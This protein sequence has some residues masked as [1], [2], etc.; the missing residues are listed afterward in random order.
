MKL[1]Y[2]QAFYFRFSL[3]QN[4]A[5]KYL[6]RNGQK[7]GFWGSIRDH[8]RVDIR[9]KWPN[10]RYSAETNFFCFGRTLVLRSNSFP[11][12]KLFSNDDRKIGVFPQFFKNYDP[13][14]ETKFVS[15]CN[16]IKM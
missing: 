7:L 9:W 10:I 3:V 4:C 14:W 12:M 15:K 1:T 8:S 6:F 5:N 2:F 16:L 13:F 11:N